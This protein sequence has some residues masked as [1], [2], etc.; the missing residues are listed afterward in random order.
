MRMSFSYRT[1]G[2][3]QPSDRVDFEMKKKEVKSLGRYWFH[4]VG[5][6][7]VYIYMF[8]PFDVIYFF[9]GQQTEL[10]CPPRSNEHLF[11]NNITLRFE[12]DTKSRQQVRSRQLAVIEQFFNRCF[13]NITKSVAS[14]VCECDNAIVSEQDGS[15][16]MPAGEIGAVRQCHVCIIDSR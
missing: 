10:L 7:I 14:V 1:T 15:M 6:N 9:S 4:Y 13:G 11:L 2:R 5:D 8:I 12:N 3:E 16:S